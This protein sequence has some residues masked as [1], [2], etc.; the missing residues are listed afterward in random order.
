MTLY[1]LSPRSFLQIPFYAGI[2]VALSLGT[3]HAETEPYTY[4]PIG[5]DFQVEFPEQPEIIRQCPPD[6]RR[7]CFDSVR[8]THITDFRNTVQ[9]T[10]S[11]EPAT[12]AEREMMNREIMEVTVRGMSRQNL[13]S[14]REPAPAVYKELDD[15]TRYAAINDSQ[16]RGLNNE[17]MTNQVWVG[18]GS[19][20]SF[21]GDLRGAD[22]PATEE[23]FANIL[24]SLALK[25]EEPD[26]DVSE[27]PEANAADEAEDND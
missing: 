10:V 19:I 18:P 6:P 9:V 23:V 13:Q 1:K 12:D 7:D 2:A 22:S 5:C 20:L 14:G 15:G 25:T 26:E 17:L 21:R 3:A 27:D 24:Q 16:R 11:C 4:S 8:F